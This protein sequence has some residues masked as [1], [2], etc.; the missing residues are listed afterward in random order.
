MATPR[1]ARLTA[2]TALPADARLLDLA[3]VGDEPLGFRGGQY[4][5]VDSGLVLPSSPATVARPVK[6]TGNGSNGA[7]PDAS[8]TVPRISIGH[9][10]PR[11]DAAVTWPMVRPSRLSVSVEAPMPIAAARSEASS[12]VAVPATSNGRCASAGVVTTWP[13]KSKLATGRFPSRI[14]V[15]KDGDDLR[16]RIGVD[17]TVFLT[18]TSAHGDHIG[19]ITKIDV[20]FLLKRLAKLFASHLF[21][22]PR[23]GRAISYLAQRKATRPGNLRIIRIDCRTCIGL[24][25]LWNNQKLKGLA[26]ERRGAKSLQIKHRNH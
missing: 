11:R 26:G 3:V 12:I 24:N 14:H 25:K 4:I 13:V 19:T 8:S 2:A 17:F 6:R 20:K 23:K 18:T 15:N 5:I 16:I 10:P 1:F 7:S 21:D 9:R 22:Q